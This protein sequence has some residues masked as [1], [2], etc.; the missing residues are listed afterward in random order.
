[1]VERRKDNKLVGF[2]HTVNEIIDPIAGLH[3]T[4]ISNWW[5]GIGRGSEPLWILRCGYPC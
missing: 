3:K 2:K 5:N 4:S 1:M